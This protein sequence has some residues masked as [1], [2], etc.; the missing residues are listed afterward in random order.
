MQRVSLTINGQTIHARRGTTILQAARDQGIEIPTLCHFPGHGTRAVC[1]V[2]VVAL[3][4]SGRMVPACATLVEAGMVIETNGAAV[5]AARRVLMEFIL[6][7]HGR[8]GEP[9]CA[10]EQLADQLG[11]SETRFQAPT[12]VSQKDLSSDFITVRS[13]LC[14]HCDRCIQVC[15]RDQ[16]VIARSGRGAAVSITFDDG[17][18]M[19]ESSC[20]SCGD[21]IAVCPGAGLRQRAMR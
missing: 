14:V 17:L 13:G 21:C 20:T 1:R 9:A 10:I 8:C 16:Q 18:T 6:A 4:G 7:E 19:T 3:E 11:V 2:C 5:V 12:T 15:G